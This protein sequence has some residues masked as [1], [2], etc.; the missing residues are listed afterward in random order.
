MRLG[1]YFYASIFETHFIAHLEQSQTNQQKTN[2]SHVY[3]D[4]GIYTLTGE[5][6]IRFACVRCD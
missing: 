2:S 1:T 6:G 5:I 4:R 3:P